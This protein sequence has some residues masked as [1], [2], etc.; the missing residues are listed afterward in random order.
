MDHICTILQKLTW[1][2]FFGMNTKI[3]LVIYFVALI[4]IREEI[5]ANIHQA[6]LSQFALLAE[7]LIG[8]LLVKEKDSILGVSQPSKFDC[9]RQLTFRVTITEGCLSHV[10]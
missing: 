4:Q 7:F 6:I 1:K 8:K 3:F 5:R 10:A 9:R 2:N